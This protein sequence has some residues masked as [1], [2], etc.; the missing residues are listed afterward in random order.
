M[1]TPYNKQSIVIKNL[2]DQVRD[3]HE[4]VKFAFYTIDNSEG[5]KLLMEDTRQKGIY[6]ARYLNPDALAV[7]NAIFQKRPDA[8]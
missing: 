3:Q 6:R 1:Q 7:R 4:A 5:S 8:V 2:V